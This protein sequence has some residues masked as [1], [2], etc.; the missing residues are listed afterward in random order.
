[1]II[2]D[3]EDL[4]PENIQTLYAKDVN[5]RDI[6]IFTLYEAQVIGNTYPGIR[7]FCD[8]TVYNPIRE[9][10]MSLP[11]ITL[12]TINLVPK[13][14]LREELNPVFF[15]IYNA[16][17][18]YHN[19]WDTLPYLITYRFLKKKVPTLK[20]LVQ[21]QNYCK[22]V[23]EFLELLGIHQSD[24]LPLDE[25]TSYLMMFVSSSYTH[26][27]KSNLPP[28]EEIYQLY[29]ELADKIPNDPNLPRKIYISRRSHKHGQYD[30]IGTDYTMRRRLMNEDALVEYLESRGYAEIFTEL[31]ST[32]EKIALF[33]GCTHVVGPI[34]GGLCNVLFCEQGTRLIPIV[35]PHFLEINGRFRYSFA[36]VNTNYFFDTRHFEDSFFKRNMRVRI[37]ESG[38]IGEIQ[39]ISGDLL[40]VIY[41]NEPVAGWNAQTSYEQI[42]VDANQ[43]Q[44]LDLGLNSAWVMDLDKFKELG[45]V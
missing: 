18:Y 31:L 39:D 33:K 44:P 43:V 7:L 27:G 5:G 20:L 12:N 19:L 29:K 4:P 23:T 34:G 24:L 22:F 14:F 42:W 25:E 9:Q 38:I 28:R 15:F 6:K 41:T 36:S 2:H 16:Q 8:D 26:G 45:D 35:S 40:S 37:K 10:V 32:S 30:N 1:M 11:G 17:N 13:K 3:L 21:S